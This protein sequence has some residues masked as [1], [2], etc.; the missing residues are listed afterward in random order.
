MRPYALIAALVLLAEPAGAQ[1]GGWLVQPP[2]PWNVPGALLP[3]APAPSGDA[4]TDPR[5]IGTIREAQT[6]QEQ[7][8]VEAGWSLVGKPRVS[9]RTT[10]L[11]A[12][13]SVDGMCRPW[14]FQ[15]FV[16]VGLRFAGTLS[17]TVM[18]SRTDGALAE[19][20]FMSGYQLEAAFLRYADDDPLC[21]PSRISAVRYRIDLPATLPRVVPMSVWSR[22]TR[23]D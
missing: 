21:C 3:A 8:L 22:P 10:V 11:L 16:F 1:T 4:P 2:A 5:C 18:D 20:R 9:G 14:Q 6:P 12:E 13:A 15:A 7:A 19:I 17:P 23:P